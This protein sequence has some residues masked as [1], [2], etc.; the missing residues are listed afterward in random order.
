MHNSK[1]FAYIINTIFI[2][3]NSEF[4]YY[5][6]NSYSQR[7]PNDGIHSLTCFAKLGGKPFQLLLALQ[8]STMRN[9]FNFTLYS[10]R[11]SKYKKHDCLHWRSHGV[12]QS[13]GTFQASGMKPICWMHRSCSS[14][15][16]ETLAYE[17]SLDAKLILG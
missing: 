6:C 7:L 5:P 13:T 10:F 8:V 9:I 1:T 16:K 4:L 12:F 3:Q 17:Q 11:K 14:S 2:I 15:V